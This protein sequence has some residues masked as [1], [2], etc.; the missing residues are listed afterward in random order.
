MT[1]LTH[2]TYG[3]GKVKLLKI[4]KE[5][6]QH[7]VKA[8][9]VEVEVT[10]DQRVVKSFTS[11]DN[12]FV[13]PTDTI[14]NTIY[15]V[16]KKGNIESSERYALALVDH[17]IKEYDQFLGVKIS[18]DESPW[19]RMNIIQ[20]GGQEKFH[21]HSFVLTKTCVRVVRVTWSSKEREPIMESGFK[22]LRIMKTTGSGFSRFFTDKF[23]VLKDTEDRILE[24]EVTAMWKY[25]P[26]RLS[27]L[28]F[29][30]TWHSIKQCILNVFALRYSYS[31]QDTL[32]HMGDEVLRKIEAVDEITI[33]MPNLH[34]VKPPIFDE[35]DSIFVPTNEP[36]GIIKATCRRAISKL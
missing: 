16:A 20:E 27:G 31:V 22:K 17:F 1:S 5:K 12:S 26:R 2:H 10:G 23:T 7:D 30:I 6:P 3:K 36:H 8:I 29:D 21:E 15:L 28:H 18:I 32:F 13:L 4:N 14:K 34:N 33:E 35:R 19:E 11:A 24:T 9:Q 25:N